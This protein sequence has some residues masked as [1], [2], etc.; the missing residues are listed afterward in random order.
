MLGLVGP[1][2]S[3]LVFAE[4]ARV[5]RSHGI[6][7]HC[8]ALHCERVALGDSAAWVHMRLLSATL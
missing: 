3:L 7:W 2:P 4:V 5:R 6:A 1:V 8:I